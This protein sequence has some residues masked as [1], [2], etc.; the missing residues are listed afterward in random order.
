MQLIYAAMYIETR[1]LYGDIVMA[2]IVIRVRYYL[3]REL[4]Y[5]C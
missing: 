2:R 1:T 4:S 3:S 5:R